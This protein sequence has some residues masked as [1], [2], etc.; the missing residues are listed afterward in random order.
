MTK[1]GNTTLTWRI[2]LLEKRVDGLDK[3]V[4]EI[5]QNHLP[6]LQESIS[7]LK[8]RINVQTTIQVGA[9]ILGALILKYL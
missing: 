2:T 7:S 3:K 9:I 6:H 1:N 5:L 4:D 8:T